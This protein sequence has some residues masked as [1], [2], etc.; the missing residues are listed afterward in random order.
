MHA[1]DPAPERDR[2]PDT[3]PP[4]AIRVPPSRRAWFPETGWQDTPVIDRAG[5][6]GRARTGPLIVQ[7]YDATCLVPRGV[8]VTLDAFGNIR[9]TCE[10]S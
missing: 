3:I 4:S 10:P 8:N 6:A 1:I 2:L 5:L 9:L 7:E